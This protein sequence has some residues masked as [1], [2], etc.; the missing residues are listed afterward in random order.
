M[1]TTVVLFAG[2]V[3]GERKRKAQANDVN[4]KVP[5][6]YWYTQDCF[7]KGK[8]GQMFVSVIMKSL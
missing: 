1:G 3:R 4:K 7:H 2:Q 5:F 8:V 6:I